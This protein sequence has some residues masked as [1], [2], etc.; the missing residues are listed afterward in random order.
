[1]YNGFLTDKGYGIIVVGT[2]KLRV[3]RLSAAIYLGYDISDEICQIL[4]KQ[5]CTNKNCWN[6]DHLYVGTTQDNSTDI[7]IKKSLETHC[8]N[9]HEYTLENTHM[10]KRGCRRCKACN[11]ER[12]EARYDMY[13]RKYE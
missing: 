8:K 12:A 4:H 10:D 9:G 2:Q 5:E 1:M 13:V 7:R 6:P 3:H 11:N